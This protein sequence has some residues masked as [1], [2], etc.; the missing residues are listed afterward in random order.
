[1]FK[2][3]EPKYLVGKRTPYAIKFRYEMLFLRHTVK[4]LIMHLFS[5]WRPLRYELTHLLRPV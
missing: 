4:K 5:V 3:S 1:M 2:N